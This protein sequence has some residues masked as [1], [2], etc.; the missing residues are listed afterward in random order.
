VDP[1]PLFKVSRGR[2]EVQAI[3]AYST[4]CL[5]WIHPA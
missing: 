1:S 5:T 3:P 2:F 4:V